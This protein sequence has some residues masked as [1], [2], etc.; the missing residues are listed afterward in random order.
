MIE[1][2]GSGHPE[3]LSKP[4]LA[5]V[6]ELHRNFEGTRQSLLQ[7]RADRYRKLAA[8]GSFEFLPET[9]NV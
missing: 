9:A 1:V 5:F 3:I 4:A 2:N 8:G 6:E 7:K